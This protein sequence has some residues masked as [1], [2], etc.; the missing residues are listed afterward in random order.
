MFQ[1]PSDVDTAAKG[2]VNATSVDTAAKGTVNTTAADTAARAQWM[3]PR[4]RSMVQ[5]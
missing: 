2:T 4:K 5:L 3:Q 1:A